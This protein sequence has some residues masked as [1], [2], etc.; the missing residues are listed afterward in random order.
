[1]QQY[2]MRVTSVYGY[3]EWDRYMQ[4]GLATSVLYWWPLI[5]QRLVILCSR[6]VWNCPLFIL[7]ARS[8]WE[9]ASGGK[10]ALFIVWNGSRGW[11]TSIFCYM[12]ISSTQIKNNHYTSQA[13]SYNI[14]IYIHYTYTTPEGLLYLCCTHTT[15]T[16]YIY[17]S[18]AIPVIYLPI[19]L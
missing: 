5:E 15:L 12:Y 1:M 13:P 18:Y 7:T 19:H 8:C 2:S 6:T 3:E 16:L 9:E 17:Y 11:N 4:V 10:P 14:Y